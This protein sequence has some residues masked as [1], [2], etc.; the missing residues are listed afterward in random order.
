MPV[1]PRQYWGL[2]CTLAISTQ[3]QRSGDLLDRNFFPALL[4][5]AV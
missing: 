3:N 4:Q 2:L 1:K 5:F